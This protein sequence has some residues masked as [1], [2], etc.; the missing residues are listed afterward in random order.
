MKITSQGTFFDT[1]DTILKDV[2]TCSEWRLN[3]QL[4][5]LH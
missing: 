3:K 4:C 1:V 5:I 2:I